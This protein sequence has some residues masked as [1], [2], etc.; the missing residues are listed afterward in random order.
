MA[1]VDAFGNPPVYKD[2]FN[3]ATILAGLGNGS[4]DQA[5][6]AM[7]GI[8]PGMFSLIDV[9]PLV[10]NACYQIGSTFVLVAISGTANLK[11]W[12]GNL[13]GSIQATVPGIPGKVNT[14]FATSAQAIDASIGSIVRPALATR[15]L[16]LM[17]H[18][19]G[20]A[21]ADVL[22]VLW[23]SI[24]ESGFVV[25]GFGC[26][27]IGDQDFADSSSSNFHRVEDTD[28]G[29]PAVPPETWAG[30]GTPW[31]PWPGIVPTQYVHGGTPHTL[32]DDGTL[33]RGGNGVPFSTAVN[34]IAALE[35]PTHDINEYLRRLSIQQPP[36]PPPV[37]VADQI[38]IDEINEFILRQNPFQHFGG[39]PVAQCQGTIFFRTSEESQGWGE[40]WF[41]QMDVTAMLG[42]INSLLE[43]RA[44]SLATTCEI[45]AYRAA[46]IDTP[47]TKSSRAIKLDTP[48]TGTGSLSTTDPAGKT[49]QTMDAMDYQILSVTNQSRR[50]Y[51]FR[52]IPDSWV[53]GSQLSDQGIAGKAR[54]EAYID[55]VK[56]ASLGFRVYLRSNPFQTISGITQDVTSKALALLVTL[57][58]FPNTGVCTVRG[59]KANPMLNGRWKFI[60]ID[61]NTIQ[62]VGSQRF[63]APNV[64]SGTVQLFGSGNDVISARF[65]DS[66]STRKTG[67]P[68][69]MRH[70]KRSP[71]LLHH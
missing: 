27:R 32:H 26:P 1:P 56:A 55:A 48:I 17:G 44:K 7:G 23:G 11:Q 35:V 47:G 51:P 69:G 60:A 41:A 39:G 5:Q 46:I 38:I 61:A 50:I 71:R 42:A 22:S 59:C 37:M 49:N 57:H 64:A 16:V 36:P 43:E 24:A 54:I 65:F 29:I 45:H 52:G 15:R 9:G 12:I 67:R 21:I 18:S 62:L 8:E 28:D 14:F 10:P 53:V 4:I 66:V 58:G 2:Y 34:Q 3:S 19:L 6:S 20:A 40:S 33:S 13:L 63:F 31:G 30:L 70:G 68:F 25:I